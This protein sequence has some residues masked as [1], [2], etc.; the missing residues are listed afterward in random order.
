VEASRSAAAPDGKTHID[1]R[2]F[3]DIIES[4]FTTELPT[5]PSDSYFG[6]SL[7]SHRT[8]NSADV[9]NGRLLPPPTRLDVGPHRSGSA[10]NTPSLARGPAG[11]AGDIGLHNHMQPPLMPVDDEFTVLAQSYFAQGQDFVN[12]D[13]W[14]YTGEG[15]STGLV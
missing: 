13:D 11:V 5:E 12:V 3:W 1:L 9:V 2:L 10:A 8:T 4:C 7:L 14:W 15:A 6:T